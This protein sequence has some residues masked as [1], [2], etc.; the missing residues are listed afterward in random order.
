MGKR[1][2]FLG[3]ATSRGFLVRVAE[4]GSLKGLL[5]HFLAQLTQF[6]RKLPNLSTEL[7]F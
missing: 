1:L 2:A 7:F 5:L 3:S 6:S 4:V